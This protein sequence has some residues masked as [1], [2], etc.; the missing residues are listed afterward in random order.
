M[1]ITL[2]YMETVVSYRTPNI[3][4]KNSKFITEVL[5]LKRLIAN[6]KTRTKNL[7]VNLGFA[8]WPCVTISDIWRLTPLLK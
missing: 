6:T 1:P 3:S 8:T 4:K 2:R 7:S 5:K